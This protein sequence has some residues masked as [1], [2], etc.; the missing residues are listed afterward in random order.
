MNPELIQKFLENL[1]IGVP[2]GTKL[3]IFSALLSTT[4]LANL[5]HFIIKKRPAWLGITERLQK[6]VADRGLFWKL[7]LKE[8]MF[9]RHGNLWPY[10]I[11]AIFACLVLA[12]S[13]FIPRAYI[14]KTY[15]QSFGYMKSADEPLVMEFNVP[16]DFRN[17]RLYVS[18]DVMGAWEFDKTAF[19]LPI[20]WRAKF[21]PSE[22]FYPGQK[23][24]VY[25]VG[26]RSFLNAKESH[27]QAVEFYAPKIPQIVQT[28]PE[29][30][31]Q[32]IKTDE[33]VEIVFDA[34]LGKFVEIKYEISPF[35]EFIVQEHPGKL[36]S[37]KEKT[38][39]AAFEV[40]EGAS[41]HTL[42]FK[43]PLEQDQE[44]AL[45]IYE[46]LRSYRPLDN[47]TIG[48]GETEKIASL[49]FKT[50][51]TPLISS[52][53]PKGTAVLP[54]EP[55]RIEFAQPMLKDS[56]EEKLTISPETE[57][58]LAWESES[59]LTFTPRSLGEVGWAN[60]TSYLVRFEE[61]LM[62]VYGGKT[63][64][65]TELTFTTIGKVKVLS[66]NPLP[67]SSGVDPTVTNITV[68]F[69]QPVDQASTQEHFSLAPAAAGGFSWEG[70]R[71]TYATAGKLSYS[72][73]YEIK[74]APGVKTLYGLDSEEEFKSAFT[75]RSQTFTLAVP[76]YYQNQRVQNFDC[77]LAAG[78]MV[79]AYRGV[80]V[81]QDDIRY[82]I[83]IGE[84]PDTHWVEGYGT[85]PDPVA[86]YLRSRGLSVEIKR[87]W[88][89]V[90]L[91]K[92]VEKGHPVIVWWYNRYSTPKG[93]FTLP[94]GYTGYKGMHNEV[95]RGFVGSS[96]KP[97]YL[98]T[99]DPWRG[100]LTYSRS[101]F[102]ATW[103]YINYTAIVVY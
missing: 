29:E 84:N 88:N 57:G 94:G 82:G 44:Y 46:T 27:E 100:Q 4:F 70:N 97:I 58:L 15:P 62:S 78:Q 14:I 34:P 11:L 1:S 60:E 75:T 31:A 2:F 21:Y 59:V 17:V 96:S 92:E 40:T 68:E 28:T 73:R 65:P 48:Q 86:N 101:L 90:A 12:A 55:L 9:L 32:N 81:T 69:D 16:V 95:V 37:A 54:S 102:E 47:E 13:V 24:V 23:I 71:M 80:N 41:A 20:P 87:G 52:Y 91:A 30:G 89:T 5:I 61:G 35:V 56:V 79:L 18:P 83:G 72:T 63:S 22:S 50:V 26:L 6:H 98:L 76:M 53:S 39:H 85:H 8:W 33:M 64:S 99:N 10:S 36:G 42:V 67:E 66:F 3:L 45:S 25:A 19:G 49:T 93:T 77:N 7:L 51:A 43:K 74:I 103:N 38:A